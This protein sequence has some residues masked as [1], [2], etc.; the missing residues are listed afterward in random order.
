MMYRPVAVL[1][2]NRTSVYN[3]N[4]SNILNIYYLLYL[5]PTTK[6]ISGSV[7][8]QTFWCVPTVW[9]VYPYLPMGPKTHEFSDG[10]D[11][12]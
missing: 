10:V 4:V 11:F 9:V 1:Y 2:V 5:Y 7:G 6:T 3:V 12:Y 8:M